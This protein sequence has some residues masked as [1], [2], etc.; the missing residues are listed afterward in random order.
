MVDTFF[1]DAVTGDEFGLLASLQLMTTQL[2]TNAM[3]QTQIIGTFFDAK[4]QLETQRLFQEL[5]VRAHKDYHPSEALCEFGTM[6]RSLTASARKSDLSASTFAKRAINRQLL[7][8]GTTAT[9]GRDSDQKSRLVQFV[10]KYCN[11]ADNARNLNLLCLKSDKDSALYNKDINYTSTLETPQTLELDFTATGSST[12]TDEEEALFALTA[13]LFAHNT[14]PFVSKAKFLTDDGKPNLSAGAQ[15]YM[16]ARAVIAKRSVAMNSV[17]AIAAMKSQGDTEA[18]PFI[19]ALIEE[20]GGDQMTLAE[21]KR[22]IGD[23]PSYFAQ[24]D[25]LTKKLYQM[26]SFYADLYDKP[27]NV[28][29]K[30]VAVQAATLMQKRDSYRSFLRSEMTLATMLETALMVEQERVTNEVNKARDGGRS[31]NLGITK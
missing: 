20:M 2:V 3:Q 10:K 12:N 25:V 1:K 26:P 8:Q 22:A 9:R 4:H 23:K 27:A 28:K 7:A 21:I 16:D 6:T 15:D 29:R 30:N 17:A 14:F 5:T 31:R 11:P 24:M 13:N 18:T 19:Y